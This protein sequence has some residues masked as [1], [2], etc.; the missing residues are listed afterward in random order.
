MLGRVTEISSGK[1]Y[2]TII[3]SIS[4]RLTKDTIV[5]QQDSFNQNCP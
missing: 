4:P 1:V 5:G 3:T 2:V